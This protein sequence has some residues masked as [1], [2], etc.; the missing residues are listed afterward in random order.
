AAAIPD[1]GKGSRGGAGLRVPPVGAAAGD[2]DLA[3]LGLAAVDL[4]VVVPCF[5]EEHRLPGALHVAERCL[6]PSGRSFELILVD[7]CSSDQ[8]RSLIQSAQETTPYV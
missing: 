2:G 6:E 3:R 1:L 5:N 7:D 4:S 8:T